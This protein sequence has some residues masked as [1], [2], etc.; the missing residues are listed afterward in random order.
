MIE[1]SGVCNDTQVVLEVR[2]NSSEDYP[3]NNKVVAHLNDNSILIIK[4][5]LSY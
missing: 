2:G 1:Y 5:N 3:E 4:D